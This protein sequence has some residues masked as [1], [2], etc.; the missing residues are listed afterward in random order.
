MRA[1]T[2]LFFLLGLHGSLFSQPLGDT[3]WKGI[4]DRAD[5]VVI[6]R[7]GAE[8][9]AEHIFVPVDPL[10]YIVIGEETYRWEERD[11]ITRV[12]ESC[13]FEYD[14]GLDSMHVGRMNIAFSITPEGGLIHDE[15]L[16]G[17]ISTSA[18]VQF[19][20]HLDG[21][22]ALA[23]KNGVKC[24][25]STAFR[26]LRWMPLDTTALI[27]PAGEGRYE[28]VLGRERGT[29]SEKVAGS[30]RTYLL[31]DS[32]VFDP[33]SGAVLRKEE[34]Y[35]TISWACGTSGL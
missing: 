7:F 24:E 32:I 18:P 1:L 25:R 30:V 22:L 19:H 8:F 13:Y 33:F 23:K 28:L 34:R 10:D 3:Y 2:S 17:F 9:F 11:S 29:R 35:E 6:S 27:H 26:D 21:F 5:S 16:R 4:A 15:D 14:I 12:P 31:V 20:T